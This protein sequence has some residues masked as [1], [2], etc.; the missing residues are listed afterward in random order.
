L[1]ISNQDL[2]AY[3]PV[4]DEAVVDAV[5]VEVALRDAF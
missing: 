5:A 3:S 2:I 1:A 4:H